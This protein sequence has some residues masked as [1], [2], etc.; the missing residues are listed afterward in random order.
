MTLISLAFENGQK[1]KGKPEKG[2]LWKIPSNLFLIV[3]SNE[4]NKSSV[5]FAFSIHDHII[6]DQIVSLVYPRFD[7]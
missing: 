2:A 4:E 6:D 7:I 3:Y 1:S 5:A